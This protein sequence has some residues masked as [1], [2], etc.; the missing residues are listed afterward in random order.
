M[1]LCASNRNNH[2]ALSYFMPAIIFANGKIVIA[3]DSLARHTGT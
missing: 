3:V 1:H 2:K